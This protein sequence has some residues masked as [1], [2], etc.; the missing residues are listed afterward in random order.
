MVTLLQFKMILCCIMMTLQFINDPTITYFFVCAA[1]YLTYF[2]MATTLSVAF[3]VMVVKIHFKSPQHQPPQWLRIMVFGYLAKLVRI[4]SHNG[5]TSPKRRNVQRDLTWS[6]TATEEL[7][8]QNSH[9]TL[10]ADA[11][12]ENYELMVQSRRRFVTEESNYDITSCTTAQSR[13]HAQEVNSVE[14]SATSHM[15]RAREWNEWKQIAEVLDRFF[16]Y[17]FLVFL[18]VPTVAILG[19]MRLFKPEL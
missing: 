7:K 9:N 5:V 12:Q 3:S 15:A 18:I 13:A 2:M 14:V 17:L 8:S 19:L 11:M 10:S 1:I 4:S 16:F 6:E